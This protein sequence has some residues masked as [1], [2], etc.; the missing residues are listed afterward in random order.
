MDRETQSHL[1]RFLSQFERV[2]LDLAEKAEAFECAQRFIRASGLEGEWTGAQEQI[3]PRQWAQRLPI[4][5]FEHPLKDA[6]RIYRTCG[7]GIQVI[8][9]S[10]LQEVLCAYKRDFEEWWN[11]EK[12]KW[13]A[14]KHFQD[15]W[16]IQ[17]EDFA[18]MLELALGKTFNL[19]ASINNFPRHMVI[20]FAQ[21]DPEAVRA[22]FTYLFD[23]SRD[24]VDRVE[25]FKARSEQLLAERG[26]SEKNHYQSE[27]AIST[28][29]WL[30]Y[31]DK[32]YI[33][34]YSE[35]RS[36]ARLLM[37]DYVFKKGA[38]AANLRNSIALY[39]EICAY[40]QR[41]DAL[42]QLLAEKMD[43][44]CYPDPQL[45]TLTI[46]VG[47]YTSR[48]FSATA[49]SAT[50]LS[51]IIAA[52]EEL[53]GS[54]H[55][56]DI[57]RR[58]QER[59]RT[60]GIQTNPT[61]KKTVSATI[62]SHS[63]DTRSFREGNADIFYSVEGLGNGI[64]GLRDMR[65]GNDADENEWFPTDYTPGFTVEKWVE[66]LNNR[67]IFTESSLAIMKRMKDFGGMAT[68]SQLASHYGESANFYN[69][70][71][72]TLA[73]RIA[74]ETGC[75]VMKRDAGNARWWPILYLGKPA[76]KDTPGIYVWKLR[77][78]L[79]AALERMDL[80]DI[81]LYAQDESPDPY[82]RDN[83][84][85][86]VYMSAEDFDTLVAL[87]KHKKNVILQGAPGVG[88]TFAA[89]RLAY[90]MMGVEDPS[91]V[92]LV[93]FHQNYAYE[94][95]VMGYR[96]FGNGFT[97]TEGIF[98]AFCKT[99]EDHADK[100]Y[101]FIIDEINRGNMSKIFGELLMLIEKDYRATPATLA[102]SRESFSVPENLYIIGMMNTADRSL[103]MIDYAL[104]RRF[105][106]FDMSPAFDTKG[107]ADY[108][109]ALGD[110][111]FDSLIECIR[112]LNRE[113]RRD[114]SLGAGFCIGHSYF[115]NQQT[116]SE[117]W[118]KAVVYYDI[119]PML[120]EY[121]FDDPGKVDRWENRLSGVF[122]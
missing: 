42:K 101:F 74:R 54:A 38:L 28:Y 77:D 60:P 107:F 44:R 26:K 41:D 34:K 72:S 119:L 65:P 115:C 48:V 117:E 104:R 64:W 55:L 70:G 2:N 68:C 62:Q 45:H 88:K 15:H 40:I 67:S 118:M 49:E 108:Q 94:D 5:Q 8:D 20:E 87:L 95:F 122:E 97:L 19:L 35:V 90:A 83:F 80:S 120:R 103:A 96:P 24:L 30:R 29:L 112:D 10:R 85:S 82:T 99:A 16:T 59:A 32:Y 39:D 33:Y 6:L 27:N 81:R 93:Q 53:G 51:E 116:C 4:L 14:V 86:E 69:S 7:G 98:Y 56:S 84:L 22:A 114:P 47:F 100:D 1:F 89:R 36:V 106:F 18:G 92:R 71:S 11:D 78:E 43:A 91:R 66:L 52:L 73:R 109:A 46:D 3:A 79:N 25:H 58:M 105:S 113:I 61:W 121:W 13:E 17:A 57:C 37:S 31:P 102:Y 21:A 111:T 63:S 76:E 110:E 12:Y 9:A 75:P 23:E 50:H